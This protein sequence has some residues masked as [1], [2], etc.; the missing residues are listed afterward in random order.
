MCITPIELL[1]KN[2]NLKEREAI[3]EGWMKRL[4]TLY[5]YGLNVRA[6]TCD[7]MDAVIAV[8]SSSTVIYSKFGKVNVT[9]HSRGGRRLPSDDNDFDS[10]LFIDGLV[11]GDTN[12]RTIRTRITQLNYKK[13]KS[14]YISA[15]K[16]LSS[17]NRDSFRIQILRVIKDLSLFRCKAVWSRAKPAKNSNFLIVSYENKF[18]EDLGLN[19]LL[20]TP[21]IMNLCPLSRSAAMPTVSYKYPKTIRSSIV[22]YRQTHEANHDPNNL[23]C[24]CETN[25]FKDSYHNHVVTGNLEII[26][27]AELRTLLQKG[28]N[29]RDQAPPNKR[30]AYQAVKSSLLNYIKKKSSKNTLPEIMFDGWKNSILSVVREKLDNF[31]SFEFNCVLGKEEVKNE[32]E[33]L[34]EKYVFVP[35]DKAK[36]NVSLVYKKFHVQLLHDEI[37]SDT[38]QLSTE[39]ETDIINRH[40]D[41]LKEHG[42]KLKSENKKLPYLWVS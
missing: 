16:F 33:R 5:P 20:K 31:S 25:P 35:T 34:Q 41:F 17:G 27:N 29:Y 37:S 38:Y 28:L 3:E 2:L 8:E 21:S 13:I 9:R 14:V 7:V 40:S 1:D 11:E 39:S 4:N 15:I 30:K 42:I 23:H 6:K 22:N 32:L 12:L 19:K 26:E 24:S 18:V 10:D 36:N